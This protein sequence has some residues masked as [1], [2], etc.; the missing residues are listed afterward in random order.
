MTEVYLIRHSKTLKVNNVL[1]NDSLQLQNEKAC[2]SIEGEKLAQ[3]HF[4]NQEFDNLDFLYSSNYVRAIETAKYLAKKNNVEINVCSLLGERKF[5]IS[6]FNELPSDF[7][8]K[9]LLDENYKMI[10]GESQKEVCNRMYHFLMNVLEKHKN[11]RIAIISHATAITF[12]LKKWCDIKYID[13]KINYSFNGKIL[14]EDY[15]DYCE[16]FKLVFDNEKLI[17]IEKIN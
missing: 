6:S 1:N 14:L 8:R 9:Q 10:N 7:E 12:L 3:N 16:T 4:N 11:K 5:G 13:D 15:F 17:D 2:L